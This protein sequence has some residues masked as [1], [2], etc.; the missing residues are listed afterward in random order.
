M[1]AAATGKMHKG[2][3]LWKVLYAA[4]NGYD[5]SEA[6]IVFLVCA[7]AQQAASPA[8]MHIVVCGFHGHSYQLGQL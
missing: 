4:Q 5:A 1:E 8:D 2:K 6:S 3:P 7:Y